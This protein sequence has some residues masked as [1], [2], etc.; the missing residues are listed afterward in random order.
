MEETLV[1]LKNR[2]LTLPKN[3][4]RKIYDCQLKRMKLFTCLKLL[5]D[6]HWIIEVKVQLAGEI[7]ESFIRSMSR[8]GRNSCSKKR[9]DKRIGVCHKCTK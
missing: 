8:I 1:K 2:F 3:V 6:M 9:R 5:E 4:L 7:H